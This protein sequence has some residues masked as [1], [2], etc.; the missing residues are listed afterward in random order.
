MPWTF[1]L[2]DEGDLFEISKFATVT[3]WKFGFSALVKKIF[4]EFGYVFG[5]MVEIAFNFSLNFGR[6]HK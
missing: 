5:F 3:T 2:I 4:W 6:F 1:Q